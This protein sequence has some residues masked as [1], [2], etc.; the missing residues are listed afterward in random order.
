MIS[1]IKRQGGR[2][3]IDKIIVDPHDVICSYLLCRRSICYF[4]RRAGKC[5]V[6][7]YSYDFHLDLLSVLPGP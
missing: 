2:Y 4:E 1:T 7:G 6:C 3:S 5:R